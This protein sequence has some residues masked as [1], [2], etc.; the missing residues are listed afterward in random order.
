MVDLVSEIDAALR[1][2]KPMP[3][4]DVMRWIAAAN[5]ISA[6]PSCKGAL[7]VADYDSTASLQHKNHL[8]RLVIQR[9]FLQ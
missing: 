8:L 9:S 1:S 5:D 7:V 6:L 2:D 4:D 3:R